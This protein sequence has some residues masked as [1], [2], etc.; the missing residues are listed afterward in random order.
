MRKDTEE[1]AVLGFGAHAAELLLVAAEAPGVVTDL[2]GTQAAVPVQHL[3]G[4]VRVDLL[5]KSGT[6][7][8]CEAAGGEKQKGASVGRSHLAVTLSQ[9]G[10]DRMQLKA[11]VIVCQ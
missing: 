5:V 10:L 2:L 9:A 7:Q 1:L 4:N 3:E 11:S 8:L 6:L